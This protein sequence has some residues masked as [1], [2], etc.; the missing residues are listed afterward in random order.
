M[1]QDFLNNHFTPYKTLNLRF[2]VDFLNKKNIKKK[3]LTKCSLLVLLI[4]LR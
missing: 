3:M 1:V 2:K 4:L